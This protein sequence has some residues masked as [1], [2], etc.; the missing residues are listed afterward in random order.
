MNISD[1][2]EG[3]IARNHSKKVYVMSL[4]AFKELAEKNPA[5]KLAEVFDKE[6]L[7]YEQRVPTEEAQA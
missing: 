4:K 6:R 5:G 1:K 2:L 7:M 3:K